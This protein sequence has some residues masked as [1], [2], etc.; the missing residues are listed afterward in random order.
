MAKEPTDPTAEFGFLLHDTAR[1][2]RW[3]FDRRA[4]ALGVTRSQWQV[5]MR[6]KRKDGMAQVE[7]AQQMDIQPISVS[8]LIDRLEEDGW[9]ERRDDPTDRRTKRVFLT[10][11]VRPMLEKLMACGA[12]TRVEAL[13]ELSDAEKRQLME[14]LERIRTNLCDKGRKA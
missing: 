10:S 6:L 7:L 3:N 13:A 14:L 12:A 2:L 4:S 11:K 1:L 9:V 8:R 5:L